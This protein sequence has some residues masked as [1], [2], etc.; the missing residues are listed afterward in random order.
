LVFATSCKGKGHAEVE[1]VLVPQADGVFEVPDEGGQLVV[2]ETFDPRR[3]KV[4]IPEQSL[5]KMAIARKVPWYVVKQLLSDLEQRGKNVLFLVGQRH[6]LRAF[7]LEDKLKSDLALRLL[8]YSDGKACVVAPGMKEGKCVVSQEREIDDSGVREIV[9][10]G[11]ELLDLHDVVVELDPEL[12]WAD[13]VRAIDGART[14]CRE[15][16]VRVGI[17]TP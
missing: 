11:V 17:R 14:C 9:R 15:Q 1:G 16:E 3:D 12:P 4:D 6:R 10:E 13:V 2:R 8:A 7:R 5:I